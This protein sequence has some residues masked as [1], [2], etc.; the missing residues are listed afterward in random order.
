MA[1]KNQIRDVLIIG[2]GLSGG[3]LAAA[4]ALGGL[5]V[6]V[7]DRAV[8]AQGLDACFDGRAFAIAL[9]SQRLFAGA[10]LW[11][12]MKA[13]AEPI[14]D[15]RV[16]DGP[17]TLFLH[18]DHNDI[19]DEPFGYMV[20]ARAMRQA[21]ESGLEGSPEITRFAPAEIK[22]LERTSAGVEARLND[23]QTV[24]ARL[25]VAADGRGSRTRIEAGIELTKWDY[26]QTAIVCTVKHQKPHQG[27]AHERFLPAGPFAILPLSG[28]RSNIVWTERGELA[29]QILALDDDAFMAELGRRFGDFL[30]PL[31][32]A[33]P[34]FAH[35]L[36]LQYAERS[37]D[38]RLA[39]VGDASHGMHPIAGQGLNMG[40]RDVAAI[41]EVLTDAHRLG[42]DI[43]SGSVL[44]NYERWR[45]FDNTLML[46]MTD[47]LNR[48]FSN[49]IPPVTLARDLGLAVVNS[50]PPLKKV[51]MQH[52]MGLAGELPRLMRGE[53]L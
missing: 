32:L 40:L 43:G 50:L 41:A 19:G 53:A 47:G 42:L 35:P 44:E 6:A 24:R 29:P 7:V 22:S 12:D 37:V 13:G 10:G 31:T 18:Y 49:A 52:A 17:S 38:L 23:G 30:G 15:I 51:F 1:K 45:R 48:L 4:L 28:N 33:S 20:E 26:G 21:I 5:R 2:G 16:S 14:A 9:S 11:E 3:T 34:R 39:L 27:I 8:P 46:A 25:C 36:S